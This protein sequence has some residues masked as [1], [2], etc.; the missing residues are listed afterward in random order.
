MTD[1][2]F[3]LWLYLSIIPLICLLLGLGLLISGKLSRKTNQ[4]NAGKILL[5]IA[6]ITEPVIGVICAIISAWT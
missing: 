1:E 6:I 4:L 3:T 2:T 5:G